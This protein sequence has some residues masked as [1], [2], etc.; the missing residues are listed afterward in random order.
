MMQSQAE[1]I[2]S[3][4]MEHWYIIKLKNF[5]GKNKLSLGHKQSVVIFMH[6]PV[7]FIFQ[8]VAILFSQ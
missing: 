1:I 3:S 7:M 8:S 6:W 5:G 4:S 2:K